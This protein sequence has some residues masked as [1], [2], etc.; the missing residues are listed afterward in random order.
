MAVVIS[1]H[2]SIRMR[3]FSVTK[4]GGSFIQL[5][6][7]QTNNIPINTAFLTLS[8]LL[9]VAPVYSFESNVN[10]VIR[11]QISL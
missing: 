8:F 4:N 7:F 2:T 5:I 11:N 10:Y 6:I 3:F 1:N 9:L